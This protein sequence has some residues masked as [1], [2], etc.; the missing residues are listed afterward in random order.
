MKLTKQL[1][2]Q[3][4]VDAGGITTEYPFIETGQVLKL[5]ELIDEGLL[6]RIPRAGD[7]AEIQITEK[8]RNY[9]MVHATPVI[10]ETRK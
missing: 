8:G 3:M 10:T 2:L 1:L 4:L 7:L 5:V 9:C 6:V